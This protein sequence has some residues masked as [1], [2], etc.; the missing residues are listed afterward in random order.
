MNAESGSKSSIERVTVIS[1]TICVTL[2]FALPFLRLTTCTVTDFPSFVVTEIG[3]GSCA[4][5]N[6]AARIER[7]GFIGQG[8]RNAAEGRQGVAPPSRRRGGRACA[9]RVEG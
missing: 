1:P 4:E 7:N 6:V 2:S 8:S 9:R 3:A 5:S